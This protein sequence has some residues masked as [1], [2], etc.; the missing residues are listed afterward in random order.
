MPLCVG[1]LEFVGI[2]SGSEDACDARMMVSTV[3]RPNQ[4]QPLVTRAGGTSTGA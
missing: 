3:E 2:A 1:F 4:A